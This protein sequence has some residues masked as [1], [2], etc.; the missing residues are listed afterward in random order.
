MYWHEILCG[1]RQWSSTESLLRP[2][3]FVLVLSNLTDVVNLSNYLI[4][5]GFITLTTKTLCPRD[6]HLSCTCAH[7]VYTHTHTHTYLQIYH[8]MTNI[9]KARNITFIYFLFFFIVT[10]KC[11]ICITNVYITTVSLYN[12]YS[13]MFRHFHVIIRECHIC[14]L[15]SY[16]NS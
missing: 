11:T 7:T 6:A 4:Y 1:T 15:V 8:N 12:L 3:L 16:I 13:Y 14:A 2:Y 10:N 9:T 5:L